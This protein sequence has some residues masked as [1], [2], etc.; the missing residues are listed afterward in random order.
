MGYIPSERST[1]VNELE[2]RGLVET[3]HERKAKHV[4]ESFTGR[5]L[6]RAP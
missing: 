1:D 2:A 6:I 4:T 5:L 3:T